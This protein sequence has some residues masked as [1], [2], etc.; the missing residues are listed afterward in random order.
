[1]PRG[2]PRGFPVSCLMARR[3][4]SRVRMDIPP[5]RSSSST[6]RNCALSLAS[7]TGT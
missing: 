7:A 3:P 2:D 4:S 5:T 6:R 1:M